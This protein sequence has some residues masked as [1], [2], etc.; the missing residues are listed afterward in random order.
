LAKILAKVLAFVT[1]NTATEL[2]IKSNQNVVFK[3]KNR[4]KSFRRKSA[5]ISTGTLAGNLFAGNWQTF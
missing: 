1:Q 4:R 3:K 5:K 2:C